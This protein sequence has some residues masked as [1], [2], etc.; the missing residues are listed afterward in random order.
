MKKDPIREAQAA[1]REFEEAAANF[2]NAADRMRRAAD[3][4]AFASF[5]NEQDLIARIEAGAEFEPG[6]YTHRIVRKRVGNVWVKRLQ[7]IDAATGKAAMPLPP[8]PGDF[9]KQRKAKVVRM[10]KPGTRREKTGK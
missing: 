8:V 9:L 7:V 2:S 6:R 5:Q 10:K 3:A 4:L 1:E